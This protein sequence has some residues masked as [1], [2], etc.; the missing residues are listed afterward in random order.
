MNGR[1]DKKGNDLFFVCSLIEYIARKTLNHRDEVVSAIG[2]EEIQHIYDLADVYHSENIDKIT[3]EIVQNHSLSSGNFDNVAA[4]QYHIPTHWDIGKVY[5][6]LILDVS[7]AQGKDI[8]DTLMEVYG[9]FIS[10][11][12]ENLNSSTYFENPSYLYESFV[13]GEMVL[14]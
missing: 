7:Q 6:R 3:E 9:S 4:C 1:E 14:E 11:E 2:K 8:I 10:R 12:I 5:K 13:N